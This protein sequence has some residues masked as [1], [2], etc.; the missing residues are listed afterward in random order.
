MN[1]NERVYATSVTVVVVVVVKVS[2]PSGR[3]HV[4]KVKS[5]VKVRSLN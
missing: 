3:L 2:T 5:R 1:I 4:L